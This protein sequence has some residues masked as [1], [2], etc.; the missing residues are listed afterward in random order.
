MFDRGVDERT[1][2]RHT[3]ERSF[4]TPRTAPHQK[5]TGIDMAATFATPSGRTQ[6]C[7]SFHVRLPSAGLGSRPTPRSLYLRR[8]VGALTFVAALVISVGSVAQHGLADRGDDP[9]SVP[10]IGRSVTYV[11]QPGDT[12]WSIAQQQYPGGDAAAVVDALVSLNGG[13]SLDIGQQVRLP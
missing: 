10:A 13:A 4:D 6:S 9:A 8:R 11:V 2:V 1:N 7:G 12:M 3:D 5:G